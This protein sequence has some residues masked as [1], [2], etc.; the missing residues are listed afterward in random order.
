METAMRLPFEDRTEAGRLLG[1]ALKSY[2]RHRDVIVLGLPRGG[3]PVA[4]EVA[5]LLEAPL[6]LMLVRKLGTPGREDLAMGAIATGGVSVL[7]TDVV[8]T[9]WISDET[10]EA[11]AVRERLELERCERLYRND[12]PVLEVKGRCVIV[13]DDGLA[14]GATMRAGVAALRQRK[15]S[16][17]IAAIPVGPVAAVEPLRKE[18]DEV[19]CLATPEPFFYVS[20][21]YRDFAEI[22]DAEVSRLL[23]RAWDVAPA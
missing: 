1:Q 21:W 9:H 23:T 20:H 19:V 18:S 17:I 8:T 16:R 11:V 5:S 7:N 15:P 2:A 4:F 3:V 6:D 22:S 12:R 10:I 14:T 13:V